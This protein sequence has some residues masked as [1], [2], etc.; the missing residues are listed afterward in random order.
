MLTHAKS[1]ETAFAAMMIIISALLVYGSFNYPPQSAQF[2][3]FLMVLQLVFSVMLLIRA[4]R[5]PAS[6]AGQSINSHSEADTA[7]AKLW[8]PLQIFLSVSAYIL[9]IEYI[10]YFVSTALFLCGSMAFFG[11]N[12]L[13]TMLSVTA[14]CLLIIYLLFVVLIGIR[15]PAG[16]LA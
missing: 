15:M 6:N 9:A 13:M 2:P 14:A 1:K 12:R 3:R 11:R 7:G 16:L 5:L 8:V 4:L 10:G